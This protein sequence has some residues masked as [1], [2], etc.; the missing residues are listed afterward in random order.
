MNYH[1]N[2]ITIEDF[3]KPIKKEQVNQVTYKVQI[4]NKDLINV[5]YLGKLVGVINIKTKT[6]IKE[7]IRTEHY[8]K[9]YS[10]Y[11][12]SR[13]VLDKIQNYVNKV[14]IREKSV[15]GNNYLIE[16]ESYLNPDYVYNDNGDIQHIVKIV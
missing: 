8:F 13:A 11:G 5:F 14:V 3:I 15:K 10:G 4:D 2:L 12:L 9:M 1:R 16:L 7:V 6:Y